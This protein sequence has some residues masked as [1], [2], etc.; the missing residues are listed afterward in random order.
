[1]EPRPEVRHAESLNGPP[2]FIRVLSDIVAKH[3]KEN[4]AGAP[5]RSN[6]RE[7]GSTLSRLHECDVRSKSLSLH[8]AAT[9]K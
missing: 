5:S 2:V 9:Y 4:D 7:N 1:M 8:G 3:L 6:V